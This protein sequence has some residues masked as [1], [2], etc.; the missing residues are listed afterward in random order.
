MNYLE[1]Y[2][3]RI[4]A[5]VPAELLPEQDATGLFRAYAVLGLAMGGAVRARDVHNAWV[6]WMTGIQPDH[7]ALV[8]FDQLSPRQ[9][10]QDAPFVDAIS[11]A[12]RQPG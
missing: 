5:E 11:R 1:E 6:A 3:Q 10:A 4:R 7:A 8:P 2:A 9:Q 12:S